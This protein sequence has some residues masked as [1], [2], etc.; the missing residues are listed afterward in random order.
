M[1]ESRMGALLSTVRAL[2]PGSEVELVRGHRRDRSATAEYVVLPHRR[3]PR[4]LVPATPGSA[5]ARAVRRFSAQASYSEVIGR[6]GVS[7]AVRGPGVAAFADRIVVRGERDSLAA[8][9]SGVLGV[10]VTFS[11]GVGTDR[12]NRKPVLQVFGPAGTTLA[13]AK[14]GDSPQA[15]ADVAAEA[16]ALAQLATREWTRIAIPSVVHSGEWGAMTLLLLSPLT[17]S[18]WRAPQRR[19]QA[20]RE[21]MAEL[22]TAFRGETVALGELDWLRRQR[23]AADSLR[24]PGRRATT[25]A[26][27]DRLR[28]T[29]GS[30]EWATGAWHGDWTPWNMA[31]SRSRVHLWDWE[32]FE[33]GVPMGLDHCHYAVNLVTRR[34]GTSPAAFREGL[35][36]AGARPGSPQSQSHVL[37]ALYLLA[38]AGR[39]LPLAEGPGGRSIAARADCVLET[40]VSW[41]D[42]GSDLPRM[43]LG[44]RSGHA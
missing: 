1:V 21:S 34:S 16:A 31:P 7:T 8:H 38:V 27:I 25:V 43:V 28:T 30:V 3:A 24:S 42:T 22:A 15:R 29:S 12:V 44:P 10:P 32:R 19:H 14:L 9:L 36:A 17:T 35:A 2:H 39:Y 13:F 11:I 26:C 5:R 41:V 37:G 6:L 4:L 33:T 18:P 20:P 40:L 23:V